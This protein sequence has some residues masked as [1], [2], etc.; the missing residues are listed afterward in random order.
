MKKILNMVFWGC[1]ILFPAGC[2]HDSS[3]GLSGSLA[4]KEKD[5][6]LCPVEFP[7]QG[8]CAKLIWEAGPTADGVSSLR[9]VF[10]SPKNSSD[11]YQ[12]PQGELKVF[13]RMSCCGTVM[14]PKM[15]KVGVGDFKFK[16]IKFVPGNWEVHLQVHHGNTFEE[17]IEIISLN[18]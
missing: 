18:V 1:M 10:W 2:G 16:E 6:T 8:L 14:V 9:L 11:T 4:I 13:F 12:D 5:P 7:I 15:E 3:Q 17:K